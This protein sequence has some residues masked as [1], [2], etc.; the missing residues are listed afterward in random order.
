MDGLQGFGYLDF[1]DA[2]LSF[3]RISR[4]VDLRYRAVKPYLHPALGLPG[5]VSCPFS[6][7]SQQKPIEF[8]AV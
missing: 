5:L 4:G 7:S 1:S 2:E 8:G 3:M 6:S